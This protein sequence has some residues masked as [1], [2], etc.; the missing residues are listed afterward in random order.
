MSGVAGLSTKSVFAFDHFGEEFIG[1]FGGPSIPPP[2]NGQCPN[3]NG[4]QGE[5]QPCGDIVHRGSV[6]E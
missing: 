6:E 4:A 5:Q 1:E 3:H 2:S